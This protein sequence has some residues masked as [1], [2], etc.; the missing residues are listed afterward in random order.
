[1][2]MG[3]KPVDPAGVS[4]RGNRGA[5][6]F[7]GRD[8]IGQPTGD[9][10]EEDDEQRKPNR[11]AD[12]TSSRHG[13]PSRW[14]HLERARAVPRDG[15]E[16]NTADRA[17]YR[18]KP[19]TH[20]PVCAINTVGEVTGSSQRAGFGG[21]ETSRKAGGRENLFLKKIPGPPVET[22]QRLSA[23]CTFCRMRLNVV[24]YVRACCVGATPIKNS[25]LPSRS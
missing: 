4:A 2:S 8:R 5:G 19:Q 23:S 15:F 16:R 12:S 24:R 14:L 18:Q 17:T 25:T 20:S 6:R 1:M 7:G 22:R 9:R 3:M 10:S 21:R 13:N 11:R